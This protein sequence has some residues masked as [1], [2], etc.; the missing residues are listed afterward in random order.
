MGAY[1]MYLNALLGHFLVSN[2][3]MHGATAPMRKKNTSA[4]KA[5]II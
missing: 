1:L 3:G 4:A 5:E 2:H